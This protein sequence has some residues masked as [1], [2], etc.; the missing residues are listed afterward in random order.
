[1][2]LSER[3]QYKTIA[4]AIESPVFKLIKFAAQDIGPGRPKEVGE[5]TTKSK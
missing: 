3:V 5:T 1:M 2:A 4:A